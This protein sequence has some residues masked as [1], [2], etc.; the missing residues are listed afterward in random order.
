MNLSY[1]DYLFM[2]E[3][4]LRYKKRHN[5]HTRLKREID[6]RERKNRMKKRKKYRGM[7][8]NRPVVLKLNPRKMMCERLAEPYIPFVMAEEEEFCLN[9]YKEN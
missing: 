5:I 6:D 8:V 1:P 7:P 3:M 2:V 9:I 4:W